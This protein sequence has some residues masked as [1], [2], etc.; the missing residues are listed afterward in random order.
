M[1]DWLTSIP[2]VLI[3]ALFAIASVIAF[4]AIEV[5]LP[6]R[7][8]F[9]P[10]GDGGPEA[11]ALLDGFQALVVATFVAGL[12]AAAAFDSANTFWAVTIISVE[13][14]YTSAMLMAVIRATFDRDSTWRD[15]I[16][17]PMHGVGPSVTVAAKRRRPE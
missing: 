12:A 14:L 13:L 8:I 17:R 16:A 9:D 3:I 2:D 4:S 11:L 15:W 7:R 1:E 10:P 5:A 6:G